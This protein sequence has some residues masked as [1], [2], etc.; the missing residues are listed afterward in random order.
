MVSY[1]RKEFGPKGSKFF[2]F[3]ADTFSEGPV[4]GKQIGSRKVNKVTKVNRKSQ[5]LSP[6]R[7]MAETPKVYPFPLTVNRIEMIGG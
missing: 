6:L 2:P 7:K 1:K 4:I 5:K 3:R